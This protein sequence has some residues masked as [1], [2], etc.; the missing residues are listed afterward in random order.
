M[1]VCVG[2][3]PKMV[4][5]H[6]ICPNVIRQQIKK[7]ASFLSTKL[8]C[9]YE[10]EWLGLTEN[11][12]RF[13]SFIS[14]KFLPTT[15][16]SLMLLCLQAIRTIAFCWMVWVTTTK[17]LLAMCCWWQNN[18]TLSALSVRISTGEAVRFLRKCGPYFMSGPNQPNNHRRRRLPR[19]PYIVSLCMRAC[20]FYD[21]N[22]SSTC[23]NCL[24]FQLLFSQCVCSTWERQLKCDSF[25]LM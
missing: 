2:F 1:W 11:T 5:S 23:I 9:T 24:F 13:T 4:P 21:L 14:F 20:I 22:V 8:L 25:S 17:W 6:R 16:H 19:D 18:N 10:M 7:T 3:H 15:A 12:H